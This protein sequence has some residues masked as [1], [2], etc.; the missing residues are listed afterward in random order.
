MPK[1]H[2][3]DTGL[4]NYMLKIHSVEDLKSHPQQGRIWEGLVIEQLIK[5]FQQHLVK[6]DFFYYRTSNQTEVDLIV[7]GRM[8]TIPI[9]IKSSFH[10]KKNQLQGMENFIKENNCPFGIVI[11][12]GEEIFP[13]S[14]KILQVPAIFL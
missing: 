3:R 9:E 5:K 12:N 13:L 14:D 4:L 8:G 11:N 6:S 2:L 10:T 1:G 7:E